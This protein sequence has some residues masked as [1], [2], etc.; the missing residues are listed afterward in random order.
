M[1]LQAC[2]ILKVVDALIRFKVGPQT[3]KDAAFNDLW[4]TVP[5]CITLPHS[6]NAC[7][8]S[9]HVASRV[10]VDDVCLMHRNMCDLASRQ[11][12]VA[13][14]TSDVFVSHTQYDIQFHD[15]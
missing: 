10:A 4:A 9:R 15:V 3:N 11:R 12:V 2:F 5:H 14:S 7:G 13:C 6:L 1:F 8:L